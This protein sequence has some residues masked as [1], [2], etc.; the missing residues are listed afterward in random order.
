MEIKEFIIKNNYLVNVRVIT[1]SSKKEILL[2]NDY[3]KIKINEIP[4]DGKA[5][6]AVIDLIH[7]TLKIPKNNIEIVS[8]KTNSNKKILIKL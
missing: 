8:G 1:R 6:K 3:L 7:K 2:E 4:E 5:N